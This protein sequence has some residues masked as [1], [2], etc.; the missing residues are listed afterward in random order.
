MENY[1]IKS[2]K[3]YVKVTLYLVTVFTIS[4]IAAFYALTELVRGFIR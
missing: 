4:M 3:Y 2:I 1:T